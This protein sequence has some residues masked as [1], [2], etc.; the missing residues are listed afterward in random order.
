MLVN[1]HH[2]SPAEH[3]RLL[4]AGT[5]FMATIALLIG[6]SVAVYDKAFDTVTMVTI[7]ADRA[8]L[9]L[10]A[11]GDVR[12]HGVLIGQVRSVS[13]DGHQ[14]V[15]K[16]AL[17]PDAAKQIPENVSVQILPT[18]LFGQKFV[19]FV[20]PPAP[21]GT[22][23]RSGDVIPASRV[24]TNVELSRILANLYTLLEAVDPADLNTTLYNLA[25]ALNGRGTKLGD[26]LTEFDGYARALNQHLPSVRDDLRLL[27]KVAHTYQLAT[28]DLVRVMKNATVTAR[29]IAQQ[30]AQL[31]SFMSDVTGMADVTAQVLRSNEQGI[32]RLG[33]LSEPFLRLLDTYSPEYPCLLEGLDRYT[34][35]LQQIF[36]N[37]EVSQKMTFAATQRPAY[38]AA[39]RPRY[40]M[41]GHGPWCLGLP[42]NPQR[43]DTGYRLNDGSS[44]AQ[45]PG[46]GTTPLGRT[47]ANPTS[48]FAGTPMEQQFVNTMLADRG[49]PVSTS[50]GAMGSL[51]YGPQV[52]G[53]RVR[54]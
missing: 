18:T 38:T 10:S 13:D 7:D 9:Q 49:G 6:L 28:P 42:N 21:S 19:S 41:A 52:R 46:A 8:G 50:Y 33:Q 20:D 36:K 1:V 31:S 5:A 35:R 14:A 24:D 39:D 43:P 17:Q 44:A 16:V 34:G 29:T 27:A 22:T 37:N 12:R 15:I 26:L 4:V 40:G 45:H 25:T 23:L 11:H 51:L 54:R 30:Q 47:F 2:D 32:I 3:R 48:G 53:T